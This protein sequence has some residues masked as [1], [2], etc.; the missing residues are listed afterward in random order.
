MKIV[1]IS[2]VLQESD[3]KHNFMLNLPAFMCQNCS[4]LQTNASY[5]GNL[6]YFVHR[7]NTA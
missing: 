7:S 4:N 1:H 5:A 3:M 6:L 2:S